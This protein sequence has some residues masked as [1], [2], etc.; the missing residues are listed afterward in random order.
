[1]LFDNISLGKANICSCFEKH[2]NY[3]GC[4][5]AMSRRE[6]KAIRSDFK[7]RSSSRDFIKG[8]WPTYFFAGRTTIDVFRGYVGRARRETNLEFDNFFLW[9]V[10]RS[11]QNLED[12]CSLANFSKAASRNSYAAN[13]FC[14]QVSAGVRAYSKSVHAYGYRTKGKPTYGRPT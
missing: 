7:I 2:S 3:S 11:R 1:M 10:I 6:Y 9:N 5:K 14:H 4:H 12:V 13:I 8:T